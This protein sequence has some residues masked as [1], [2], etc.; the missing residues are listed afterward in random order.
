MQPVIVFQDF[1]VLIKMICG[2]RIFFEFNKKQ[3]NQQIN[4][5]IMP[6]LEIIIFSENLV[7]WQLQ[8]MVVIWMLGCK[9]HINIFWP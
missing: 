4:K 6:K 1:L 2:T 9:F 7:A 5:N 3:L 8:P